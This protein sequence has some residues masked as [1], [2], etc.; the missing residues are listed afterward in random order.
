LFNAHKHLATVLY[1]EGGVTVQQP[2]SSFPDYHTFL[3]YPIVQNKQATMPELK[4][5]IY[6]LIAQCLA[7]ESKNLDLRL[8]DRLEVQ[9]TLARLLSVSHVS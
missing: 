5:E 4:P 2:S 8:R 3:Y 1:H 7:A 6:R 9:A